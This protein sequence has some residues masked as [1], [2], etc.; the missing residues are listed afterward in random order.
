MFHKI[1]VSLF[2]FCK[3]II[4]TTFI[5]RQDDKETEKQRDR[6]TNRHW[7]IDFQLLFSVINVNDDH[8][9]QNTLNTCCRALW[10]WMFADRKIINCS[11]QL[12]T[13]DLELWMLPIA[14][15]NNL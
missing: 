10:C 4:Y 8:R 13:T 3:H 2:M 14:I 15:I 1:V 12:E 7:L 6:K 9:Y 11:S 5:H